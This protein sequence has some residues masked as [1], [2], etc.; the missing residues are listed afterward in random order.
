MP[1]L[2][3]T[4]ASRGLGLEF[5]RQFSASGWRVHAACR[6]L[7]GATELAAVPGDVTVHK[8]DVTDSA[9]VDALKASIAD[10]PIDVLLNNAGVIGS[11]EGFDGLDYTAWARAMD[12]NIFGPMRMA[13]AFMDT[14]LASD[15]KQMVSSAQDG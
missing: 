14:V 13:E 3:V 1:T 2:L 6:G 9:S 12:T 10:E 15:R 4:G 5:T 8:V 11:R 7:D